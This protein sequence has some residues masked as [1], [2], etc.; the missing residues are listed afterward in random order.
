MLDWFRRLLPRDDR[1]FELLERHVQLIVVG[2][3]QLEA[4]LEGGDGVEEHCRQIVATEAAADSVAREVLIGLRKTFITPFDRDDIN[5]LIAAM[6]DTLDSMQ[7]TAKT[8]SRFEQRA[9]AP[10]MREIGHLI[11]KAAEKLAEA[12]PLLR[13]AVANADRLGALTEEV[14]GIEGE[15]D[16]AYDAGLDIAFRAAGND[17]MVYLVASQ[18]YEHLEEV[19]DRLE[20]AANQ[21][22][23]IVIQS[24]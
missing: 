16:L 7:R 14:V 19:A 15:T 17:A 20:D 9:F 5:E 4:L 6:D 10:H 22:N 3:A 13:R 12:V 11:R 1:F 2:A 24:V 18:I 23:A 8:I 21:I